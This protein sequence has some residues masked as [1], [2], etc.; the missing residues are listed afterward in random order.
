MPCGWL[1]SKHQLTNQLS[2]VLSRLDYRNSLLIDITSDQVSHLR[3]IQN[4]ATKVVFRKSCHEHGTPLLKKLHW[5]PDKE[6]ILFKIA[7]FAFCFFDGTLPLYL[8]TCLSVYTQSRTLRSSSEEKTPSCAKWKLKGFGH[9]SFRRPFFG[10]VFLPTSD[11]VGPSQS[12][13]LLLRPSSS[14]LSSQSY[15]DPLEDLRFFLSSIADVCVRVAGLSVRGRVTDRRRDGG[16][17]GRKRGDT[18]WEKALCNV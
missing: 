12:S 5:L 15:L 8:S 14:F 2:H 13:T 9:R 16:E 1:G 17:G 4:H 3:K 11:T 18:E 10:T 7:I 6:R